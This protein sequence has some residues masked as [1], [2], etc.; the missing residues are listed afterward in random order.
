[1]PRALRS[2]PWAA[3]AL[4]LLLAV[5]YSASIGLR[6]TKASAVTGDEPFYLVTTQSLIEDHDF[7][8]RQQYA[9]ESYRSWFD[10]APPLWTQA[11]PL[12]DGRVLSPHD[13][14][15]AVYLVP[16][17]ALGQIEGAQVQL[18]LTAALT[19]ALTFVLV[20]R[21]TGAPRLA[22]AATLAV[23]LSATA[24]VYATEVY[25]EVPAALCVVACL[26]L[27]RASL[28][29]V[30]RVVA[31]AV[32]V[33][34]LA[35][36][37]VKYAPLGGLIGL[38][39]FVRAGR[40]ARVWLVVLGCISVGTYV[41]GHLAMFGALTPY[42]SNLV[43][44]GAS[45]A[46]VVERHVSI[47]GRAYRLVGL[48]V[49]QHFGLGRWAP[50]L[51]PAVPA[52]PLLLRR[53]GL[54]GLAL[55]LVATQVLIATFVAI[56]MMGWWFPGRTLMTVVPLLAWPLTELLLRAPRWARGGLG[57]LAVYSALVTAALARAAIAHEVRLAVDPFEL[58][59][60]LFRL[61]A[62]LFPDYREWT[63]LA[64]ALHVGWLLGGLWLTGTA[65]RVAWPAAPRAL[66]LR[67]RRLVP[68]PLRR[69]H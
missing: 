1:M 66:R 48:F 60:A 38:V 19:F 4:F 68:V 64:S 69:S 25:P 21:E 10:Y 57:A 18:L 13:P 56:T 67:L 7:D 8:L 15:L 23:G 49:D 61:A 11:G 45:T 39:A 32:V 46:E 29:D 16:G 41:A 5:V 35:W 59:A 58:H 6:A 50:I 40:H 24:F 20:A 43:Y 9:S 36:L 34:A 63:P 33:T 54:G 51:L 30:P 26:L 2:V 31:I 52:L 47:A 37:G 12:P 28:L 44:D 62:P 14:G 27:L 53:G 17:F 65:F 42:N 55:V 22:W 3:V